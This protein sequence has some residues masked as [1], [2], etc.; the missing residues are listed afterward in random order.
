MKRIFKKREKTIEKSFVPILFFLM[1]TLPVV[2]V[3]G[4]DQA[5]ISD[6]LIETLKIPEGWSKQITGVSKT[7]QSPEKDLT[8]YFYKVNISSDFDFSKQSL[9]LWKQIDPSFSYEEQKKIS[10]PNS[11]G[12]DNL[13]QI[14]YDI[15]LKELKV[16]ISISREK[17]RVAYIN[18]ISGSLKAISKRSAQLNTIIKTWKPSSI[19]G[20]DYSRVT[21]KVFKGIIMKYRFNRFIKRLQK[22]SNIPGLAIGIIQDGKVVYKKNFGRTKVTGGQPVN[23]DTLFMIGSMTKPL[24]TLMMSKLVHDGKLSWDDPI[25]KFLMNWSLRDKKAAKNM[26]IRHSA[27]A[28]TGMPRRDLDFIFEIEG[29]SAEDRMKQMRKMYPT[30][31]PGETFQYS[32]YLVAAGGFAAAKS[33]DKTLSL[34]DS[35]KKAMSDLVFKPLNMKRT[36]VIN[37][38]PYIKNSAFPHAYDLFLKPQLISTKI[39][40]FTHSIAPAGSVWSNVNDILG[41]M[42]LELSVSS[43]FPNYIDRDNL[44]IR[45]KKGVQITDEKSY[46]LGL[47][48]E[49]YKGLKIVHHGGN[50]MGFTSD[51][52]F[53]PEKNIGAVILANVGAANILLIRVKL[54]ELLFRMDT[55]VEETLSFRRE[56]IKKNI[57]RAKNKIKPFIKGAKILEGMYSS[58]ELGQMSVYMKGKKLYADFGEFVT[59]LA[60]IKT[61]GKNKVFLLISPPWT[62]GFQ[63]MLEGRRFILP[64]AQEKYVFERDSD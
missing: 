5:S 3:S 34:L 15:P 25:N 54:L 13:T 53:L 12:W 27:C 44:L 51:M 7:V 31:K 23:S 39:E 17:D 14:V 19:K 40:E 9:S 33:Y 35:Y 45:R 59:E 57:E 11:E 24:T 21:A 10:P 55:K 30:T 26:L 16:I 52:F 43:L 58:K 22:E 48:L 63:M 36:V 60:E 41:Y 29:V 20:E 61:S 28:C 64:S 6:N 50:T 8:I 1:L 46:G 38:A 42:S 49:D 32:N 47:F 37:E 18:L 4:I 56:E 2:Q 62:G